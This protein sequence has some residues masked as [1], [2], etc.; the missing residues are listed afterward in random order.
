MFAVVVSHS[1][2]LH[3]LPPSYCVPSASGVPKL[4][5]NHFQ[6]KFEV[7]KLSF[8]KMGGIKTNVFDLQCDEELWFF[9]VTLQVGL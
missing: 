9:Y 2:L 4:K 3:T 8:S 7:N 5:T 1:F 6:A